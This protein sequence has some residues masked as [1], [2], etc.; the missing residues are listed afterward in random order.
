MDKKIFRCLLF[1][2]LLFFEG[3][4]KIQESKAQCSGLDVVADYKGNCLPALV[5]F[6]A[7]PRQQNGTVY[8]W[9][10]GD[11]KGQIL[12]GDTFFHQYTQPGSYGVTLTVVFTDGTKCTVS[13]PAG[14]LVFDAAQHLG[15]YADYTII[16][17]LP[18]DINL[19]DTTTNIA[20]RDWYVNGNLWPDHGKDITVSI[21]SPGYVSITLAVTNNAGCVQVVDKKNYIYIPNKISLNFCSVL[22]ENATHN[23]ITANFKASFD[24]SGYGINDIEWSF[25]GGSPSSYSGYTPPTVTYSNISSFQSVT[26]TIKTA[27]G[28]VASYS[29]VN[30][31]GK[32][33]SV[34]QSKI[35][36]KDYGILKWI[37]PFQSN[38]NSEFAFVKSNFKSSY[39]NSGTTY[40]IKFYESGVADVILG[41]RYQNS[42]CMD[43][44]YVP[45]LF[46][47]LPPLADFT[48]QNRDQCN[49]PS[50]V[51]F[52][53]LYGN[54]ITGTNTYT[55][56]FYD[57]AM[58]ELSG[59]PLVTVTK[60]DTSFTFLKN[61]VYNV[62]MIV[63]NSTGCSDTILYKNFVRI[64]I[65]DANYTY[66]PDTLCVG[67]TVKITNLAQMK[68][69]ENNKLYYDWAFQNQDSTSIQFVSHSRSPSIPILY[70]GVYDLFYSIRNGLSNN[71]FARSVKKSAIVVNGVAAGIGVS[72]NTGCTP[73]KKSLTAIV[74]A[75]Y[76]KNTPL[77][78]AWSV[79]PASDAVILKPNAAIT[80]VIF[81]KMGCYQITLTITSTGT[82][83]KRIVTRD[84]L[85]CVG[86]KA[87]FSL[88]GSSCRNVQL[89]I[90]NQSSL[91]PDQ[92]K[93]I[94]SPNTG[95][96]IDKDTAKNPKIMLT[97]PGC[98][99]I[100][101]QTSQKAIPNCYDTVSH[102]VC[103][104]TP[105]SITKVY[106]PDS[107]SHCAPRFD[108][109]FASGVNARSWYWDF[110]D[111]TFLVT[112]DT[113]PTHPYF[114][115]NN[116]GYT[117]KVVAIDSNGC[118]SDTLILKNYIKI[119]GPE[120]DFSITSSPPCSGGMVYFNNKSRHIYNYYFLY[121][122]NTSVD[123][124][125]IQPHY[126]KFVDYTRDSNVYIPTMF[127]YDETGC[128]AS[129]S[130]FVKLFRPPFEKVGTPDTSGCTPY[131][132]HFFDSTKYAD[133]YLWNFGDGTTDTTYTPVHVYT[134]PNSN[135]SGSP[136]R[137]TY[138][139]T[140]K[141][142]C[143]VT[144]PVANIYV[145]QT[146][147]LQIAY[148]APKVIC[149][150]DSVFFTGKTTV[151]LKYIKW[152]FDDGN[153]TSDTSNDLNPRYHYQFPGR[154]HVSFQGTTAFG[155]KDSTSDSS[156]VTLDTIPPA[157]PKI[158]YVTVTPTGQVQIFYEK[159][160]SSRF[161]FNTV[162]RLPFQTP[163]YTT[164][165]YSDTVVNDFPPP[166]DVDLQSYGYTIQ[167][168]DICGY[169][170]AYSRA[171]FTMLLTL[172]K[173]GNRRLLLRWNKY[174]GWDS[175]S[176][177]EVYRL[178]REK[179]FQLLAT[180]K[181]TDSI[182]IDT[183]LCPGIYTYYVAAIYPGRKYIS[184]SNI[185]ADSP[186]YVYP[187]IPVI[188]RKATVINNKS[189]QVN[190]DSVVQPNLNFYSID[191]N[192]HGEGWQ[193]S[194][195]VTKDT[196][197]VDDNVDVNRY[198]YQYRVQV[199]DQ[200]GYTGPPSDVATSILLNDYI[201][202]DKRVLFWNP[203]FHWDFGVMAYYIQLQQKDG[204]FKDYAINSLADT[205]FID[206]LAHAELGVPTCYRVYAVENTLYPPDRDT[207]YSNIACPNLPA[208]LFIPNV[209]SPN[210]D[211]INDQFKPVGLSI[212]NH[213]AGE[214]LQ[215]HFRIFNRWGE[216]IF[217][218][219]D[220]TKGWDGTYKGKP[221]PLDVYMYTVEAHGLDT[222]KFF[223]RGLVT[224]IK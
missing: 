187:T 108:H 124:N 27:S 45:S 148:T 164:K 208:R 81:N 86:T 2:I 138:T 48:S 59:S 20:K 190:W 152:K 87:A 112:K 154:H 155:C 223:I 47:I 11:G 7:S 194:Y 198:S 98:Y 65:P 140:T 53:A 175:V 52:H 180:V 77:T 160:S 82:T 72:S 9:D 199:M 16:C 170:S 15:F 58:N 91:N 70:P 130:E 153:L 93:W 61:G 133:K 46:D 63:S 143:A 220:F 210:N 146:P 66:K 120:P 4:L 23:Q 78:F 10:L 99:T 123:S 139:A 25:P 75:N 117:V 62:K 49:P 189:I 5:R 200:C 18:A 188:M 171:H 102:Q 113:N 109:F 39:T 205:S 22:R 1:F 119:S 44:L 157:A 42:A 74:I 79:K 206:S 161:Y 64:G 192:A 167:T 21:D 28:C 183:A 169:K 34:A 38:R 122:D 19:H 182:Y 55:W 3:F 126:Y 43:T 204:S 186:A 17:S 222:K 213:P 127:A 60:T 215:Y 145:Y 14:F 105:P 221:A 30:L 100:I 147:K 57:S 29:K 212:L 224:L 37:A 89:P 69:D 13:K 121:G 216:L 149:Y 95:V 217:E 195:R 84:S 172:Q 24:T 8:Y 162:Y 135:P 33:Y 116:A 158:Y 96:K 165:D 128:V 92:Y 150:K 191:R 56:H 68:D 67:D 173:A 50:K 103:I 168:T 26:L 83:C 41:I 31:V 101:L 214:Q 12:G 125:K 209:F 73:L 134:K 201:V 179:Q 218:T 114:K 141:K 88:N 80:D 156:I 159:K 142:G 151:P 6:V 137:V 94:V 115:N 144:T 193:H 184:R 110:G 203:Y 166:I 132:V 51:T 219:D 32:Y 90:V 71:C 35:C 196:F 176:V 197:I 178:N 136:Y 185:A 181:P 104:N 111:S 207:S 106:S 54:P 76:P 177:Y 211:S 40:L 174:I 107:A 129:S 163:F 97:Q 202:D 36:Q 131:V 85:V 118:P